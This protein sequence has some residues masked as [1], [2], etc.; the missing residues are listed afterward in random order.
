MQLLPGISLNNTPGA[1]QIGVLFA[2]FLFS[3]LCMQIYY[4]FENYPRD[5][6]LVKLLISIVWVLEIVDITSLLFLTYTVTITR[7]SDFS[8]YLFETA[9]WPLLA[10][11]FA[12]SLNNIIV[13]SFLSYRM[14]QLSGRWEPVI[15]IWIV[16]IARIVM[17]TISIVLV[18]KEGSLPKYVGNHTQL[19]RTLLAAVFAEDMF[20]MIGLSAG[21][22]M[23][24]DSGAKWDF[25][26]RHLIFLAAETGFFQCILGLASLLMSI[27]NGKNLIWLSIHAVAAEVYANALLLSM[28]GRRDWYNPYTGPTDTQ[29]RGIRS[30]AFD[31]LQPKTNVDIRIDMTTSV[32][33]GDEAPNMDPNANSEVDSINIPSDKDHIGFEEFIAMSRV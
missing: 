18:I 16:S 13:E 19:F 30:G 14:K 28:N 10:N 23:R 33:E 27:V 32:N 31:N 12:S 22:F 15:I 17:V 26:Y 11:L 1:L 21:F 3:I 24:R 29:K 20:I 5:R 2:I 4:F 7:F 9:P 8:V 6:L 25:G